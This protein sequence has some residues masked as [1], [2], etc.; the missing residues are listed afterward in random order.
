[1]ST[2]RKIITEEFELDGLHI[3]VDVKTGQI[4]EMHANTDKH[5]RFKGETTIEMEGLPTWK[6]EGWYKVCPKQ[7]IGYWFKRIMQTTYD[8]CCNEEGFTVYADTEAERE[9][10]ETILLKVKDRYKTDCFF[11][12]VEVY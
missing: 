11:F 1:M 4:M 9:E 10:F 7:S 12:Y 6:R 5:Y 2:K 3:Q 8:P